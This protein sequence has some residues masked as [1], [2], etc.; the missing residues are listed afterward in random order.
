[1]VVTVE[2]NVLKGGLG[3][4]IVEFCADRGLLQTQIIRMGIPDCFIEHGDKDKLCS[5]IDLTAQ[6]IVKKVQSAMVRQS[7][8]S[9][10]SDE[11]LVPIHT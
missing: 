7:I 11:S 6:G 4:E 3:S 5:T 10:T 8:R 9:T 1:M 2:E